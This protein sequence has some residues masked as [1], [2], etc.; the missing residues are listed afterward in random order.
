MPDTD[1][2]EI[3]N[4]LAHYGV[5]GMRWGIRK[6]AYYTQNV[7]SMTSAQINK[8]LE[9]VK[10]MNYDLDPMATLGG[11]GSRGGQAMKLYEKEIKKIQTT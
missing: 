1:D 7:S 4:F 6:E 11:Y 8:E 2:T 3:D 5:R 9:K 10:K